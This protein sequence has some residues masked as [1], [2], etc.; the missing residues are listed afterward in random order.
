ME[1]EKSGLGLDRGK[2]IPGMSICSSWKKK[3]KIISNYFKV[4]VG[5]HTHTE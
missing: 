5:S 2:K 4:F 3:L 1:G